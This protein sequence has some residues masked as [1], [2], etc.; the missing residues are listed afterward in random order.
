LTLTFRPMVWGK[1]PESLRDAPNEA[2]QM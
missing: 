1:T 2:L